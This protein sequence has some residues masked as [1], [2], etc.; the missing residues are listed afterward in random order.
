MTRRRA[1][2][3][4]ITSRF[5]T[6]FIF[7][8]LQGVGLVL[9]VCFIVLAAVAGFF[10][11]RIIS[12]SNDTENVSPSN[13]LLTNYES[14]TLTDSQGGE[15]EGW[16]LRG[17]RGGP[18]IILCHGFGSNR[19]ELLSLATVLQENHFNVYLFNFRGPKSKQRTSDL[20]VRQAGM[21]RSAIE[22]VTRQPGVNPRRVG[23]FGPTT[24]GYA[25]LVAAERSPL[26]KALVVD[27]IYENPDQMFDAQF[28]QFLGGGS[29]SFFLVLAEAQFHFFVLGKNLP[30]VRADLPK[31][32]NIPKLFISGR[33]A[34]ELANV[35]EELYKLAP[36]PKRLLL[37]DHTQT[38]L[39]SG[40][41]KREYEDQV[42][43][44]FLQNL[45]LRSD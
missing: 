22:M 25:A 6:G 35:T 12:T 24:G 29:S 28:N 19:S 32:R 17:R 18:A 44:F 27:T 42:V 45:P 14:L 43:S 3:V 15:H 11:Y 26:I 40:S 34:P 8:I 37:M 9:L 38:S 23:L 30:P 41:E 10:T 33:D 16:L 2:A 21:V 1:L 7:R 13:F 31:L 36:E 20:G 4:A 39:A 5:P